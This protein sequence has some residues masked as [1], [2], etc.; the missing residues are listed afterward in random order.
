MCFCVIYKKDNELKRVHINYISSILSHDSLY[1][2]D[3]ITMLI[4]KHLKNRFEELNFWSDNACHFRSF[5]LYHHIIKEIPEKN[6][7]FRCTLNFFNEYHGK[8]DVDRHFGKIQ[9]IN[10]LVNKT[11]RI[12]DIEQLVNIFE[13]SIEKSKN[14]KDVYFEIYSREKRPRMISKMLVKDSNKYQSFVKKKGSKLYGSSVFSKDINDYEEIGYEVK[15]VE[16][17][18]ITKYSFFK[19]SDHKKYFILVLKLS[20]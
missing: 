12:N 11:M 9:K 8:S 3:C 4:E 10:N 19:N 20:T 18:R 2:T 17:K 15:E 1:V 7:R 5:E 13:Q 16:D 14:S 6:E